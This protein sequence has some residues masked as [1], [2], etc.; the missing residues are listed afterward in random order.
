MEDPSD[1]LSPYAAAM[2]WVVRIT[3]VGLEMVLPGLAGQWVDQR[4]G[5]S[6]F[7]AVGV[8]IRVDRWVRGI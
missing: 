8:R 3:A 5:T 4:L 7:R 1:K 2:E 6:S